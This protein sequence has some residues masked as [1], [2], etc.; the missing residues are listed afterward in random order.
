ME[1]C[2][3]SSESCTLRASDIACITADPGCAISWPLPDAS[4]CRAWFGWRSGSFSKVSEESVEYGPQ[5][6]ARLSQ[7]SDSCHVPLPRVRRPDCGFVH[8]T[9]V[10]FCWKVFRS[11]VVWN[12]HEAS[13]AVGNSCS[14]HLAVVGLQVW[15]AARLSSRLVDLPDEA[16]HVLRPRKGFAAKRPIPARL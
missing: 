9:T 2:K 15:Q 14:H 3:L 13:A 8:R 16:A 10:V 12:S 1:A 4:C 11:R 6:N 5:Q 7:S